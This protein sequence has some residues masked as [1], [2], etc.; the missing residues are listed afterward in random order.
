[1]L[2]NWT[3][4]MPD[5]EVLGTIKQANDI[6]PGSLDQSWGDTAYLA[7]QAASEGIFELVNKVR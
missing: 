1:V 7:T 4:K 5:G 2:L 6:E 3:V